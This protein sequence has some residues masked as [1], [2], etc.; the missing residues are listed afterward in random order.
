MLVK[1]SINTSEVYVYQY[2]TLGLVH[3]TKVLTMQGY[4]PSGAAVVKFRAEPVYVEFMKQ[5]NIGVYFS[6][7]YPVQ[8]LEGFQLKT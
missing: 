4:C 3:F 6:L 5:W 8:I 1:Q 7:R 2:I